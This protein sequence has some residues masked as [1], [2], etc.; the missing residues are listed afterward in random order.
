MTKKDIKQVDQIAREYKM[1]R[2]QR[3]GFGKFLEEEKRELSRG[4]QNNKGDFTYQ[5][6]QQKA[7]EFLGKL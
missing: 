7:E 5:E 2:E 4:K 1:N 3:Y 6:S